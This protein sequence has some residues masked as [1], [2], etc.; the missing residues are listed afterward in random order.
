MSRTPELKE[1]LNNYEENRQKF[2]NRLQSLP[3]NDILNIDLAYDLA[4]EAHRPQKRD[5]GERYFEH[6]RNVALILIDECKIL[7]PDLIIS[8]LLHDT[9]EDT[10][11]FG[12]TTKAYSVWQKTA[13]YRLSKIFNP[14]IAD[15]VITL[16]KPKVNGKEITSKTQIHDIYLNNLTTAAPE[17]ILLKMCDRLHNLRSLKGTNPEKQIKTCQETLTEYFPIFEKIQNHYPTQYSYLVGQM[18][19]EISKFLK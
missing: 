10:P 9:I 13:H 11:I 3:I 17:I 4:K 16:T 19:T 18:N 12:N 7:E 8:A 15:C 5:S 2:L 1:L 6:V 14:H